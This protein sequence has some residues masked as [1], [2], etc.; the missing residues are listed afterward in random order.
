MTKILGIK[1]QFLVAEDIILIST[2]IFLVLF[3][4][5][6]PVHHIFITSSLFL[7]RS[8][9]VEPVLCLSLFPAEFSV[10]DKV[11]NWVRSFAGFDKVE[12]KAL[13]KILEQKQRFDSLNQILIQILLV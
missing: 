7:Y 4:K 10:K 9:T 13:E 3:Y 5:L 1:F 6:I 8:D 2:C 11:K 12:V